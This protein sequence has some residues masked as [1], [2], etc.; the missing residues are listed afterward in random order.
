M[1][2]P[3]APRDAKP[4]VE[5]DM[6]IR[7][8]ALGAR[9]ASVNGVADERSSDNWTRESVVLTPCPPGPDDRENRST[10]SPPGTT[11]PAGMPGPG[12]IVR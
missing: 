5:N 6:A 1:S 11:T 4:E 12:G 3:Q 8:A 9:W 7:K 10:S 2:D